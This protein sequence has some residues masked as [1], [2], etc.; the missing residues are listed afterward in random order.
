MKLYTIEN[1]HYGVVDGEE[2]ERRD[3]L[4]YFLNRDNALKAAIA[5][6]KREGY[7]PCGDE[8]T[9]QWCKEYAGNN[10]ACDS[11]LDIEEEETSD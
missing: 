4:G 2:W 10:S 3:T 5:F 7:I 6:A 1:Y 8:Y 11:Y 9:D